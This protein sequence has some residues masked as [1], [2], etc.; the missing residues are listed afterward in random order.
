MRK[1]SFFQDPGE[2]Y[3]WLTIVSLLGAWAFHLLSAFGVWTG[4]V[5]TWMSFVLF[6]LPVVV[7]PFAFAM[8]NHHHKI[9]MAK[10]QL[11][12]VRS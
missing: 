4:S 11:R 3:V 7:S 10:I 5:V 12:G 6:C 9:Q 8:M 2:W 1:K